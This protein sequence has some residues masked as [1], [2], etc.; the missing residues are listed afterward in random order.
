MAARPARN[1]SCSCSGRCSTRCPARNRRTQRASTRAPRRGGEPGHRRRCRSSRG[2]SHTDPR[3]LRRRTSQTDSSDGRSTR[4]LGRMTRLPHHNWV[5]RRRFGRTLPSSIRCS[6][7]SL[8][9]LSC[10][11][12]CTF[13]TGNRGLRNT[14]RWKCT[15]S[16]T[17]CTPTRGRRR[18]QGRP[19][20]PEAAPTR[21]SSG[22]I[23]AAAPRELRHTAYY[24]IPQLLARTIRHA[25]LGPQCIEMERGWTFGYRGRRRHSLS[26]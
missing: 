9:Q 11:R 23:S 21:S 15:P 19:R 26:R 8:L 2:S 5:R 18:E 12:W 14:S 17:S 20:M 22:A 3:A 13:P 4:L 16:R 24:R 1:T 7:C 10:S 6:R 25:G